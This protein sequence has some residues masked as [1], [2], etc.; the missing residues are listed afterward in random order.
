MDIRLTKTKLNI[1]DNAV[2]RLKKSMENI[3][4]PEHIPE[5]MMISNLDKDKLYEGTTDIEREDI[6]ERYDY[7]ELLDDGENITFRGHYKN[8]EITKF[9]DLIIKC[10]INGT[11][12]R[13]FNAIECN[14]LSRIL[15]WIVEGCIGLDLR[16]KDNTRVL[17][18]ID[19]SFLGHILNYVDSSYDFDVIEYIHLVR[20]DTAYKN[21]IKKN[22][23]S[24]KDLEDAYMML[25]EGLFE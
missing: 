4:V 13:Y 15:D 17:K 16:L 10:K 9:K 1:N 14:K 24:D 5:Y 25:S 23:E 12:Q 3:Q 2:M 6:V 7:Y 18:C 20:G 8:E 22:D 21:S 11:I 19:K